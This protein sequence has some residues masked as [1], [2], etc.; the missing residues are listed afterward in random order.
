M[1]ETPQSRAIKALEAD[2]WAVEVVE[3]IHRYPGRTWRTDA[4]GGFDLWA[5]DPDGNQAL[6]QVT[7]RTN[8]SARVRKIAGLPMLPRLRKAG[9][10][11]LVWG[12]G[13]TANG[14]AWRKVDIS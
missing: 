7:S 1:K 2:G 13:E 4:W 8:V 5:I 6:I 11:L 14:E 12:F 10:A 3:H 9:I